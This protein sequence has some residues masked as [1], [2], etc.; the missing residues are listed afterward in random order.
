MILDQQGN[1]LA[2]KSY[3]Q[4]GHHEDDLGVGTGENRSL[5]VL[6]GNN[7]PGKG[8]SDFRVLRFDVYMPPIESLAEIR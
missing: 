5:T 3:D 7:V 6:V 4:P 2:T 1:A 8:Q